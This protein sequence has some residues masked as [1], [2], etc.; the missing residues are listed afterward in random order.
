MTMMTEFTA[1][2]RHDTIR[3]PAIIIYLLRAG[4][5]ITKFILGH[6]AAVTIRK[7]PTTGNIVKPAPTITVIN[8]FLI[9][10]PRII[11]THIA[12]SIGVTAIVGAISILEQGE[13]FR[14]R[15]WR[16]IMEVM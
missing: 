16:T 4:V 10:T 7:Q 2:Y 13:T 15:K 1:G 5:I 11:L 9:A 3:I 8:H 14:R 6:A 12:E